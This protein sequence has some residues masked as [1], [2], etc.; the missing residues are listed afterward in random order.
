MRVSKTAGLFAALTISIG[1]LPGLALADDS[2][3]TLPEEHPFPESITSTEDGTLYVS[4]L[5]D[6]GVLRVTPGGEPEIWIEPGAF[7]T[8]S[9]LGVLVDEDRGTLWVCSNDISALGVKGPS[10][11]EGGFLKGFDL[12]T[13]KGKVSY[14]MPSEKSVCN[15]IAIAEDGSTYI[16]NVAGD[17][18]LKL[19]PD[20]DELEVWFTDPDVKGGLDGLAFGPDGNLYANTYTGG[21]LFRFDVEDG[22]AKGFEKLE[23]GPL[24]KPDGIRP[25]E[26]GLVMVQGG[27]AL[28]RITIDDGKVELETIET[29]AEPTGV[30]VVGDTVWVAEGQLAYLFDKK[31]KEEPRPD[32]NLR[33][34]PLQ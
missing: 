17:E 15:D 1:A 6:G 5:S 4:S 13:G 3:I 32:F 34:V 30:T 7:E 20:A 22:E 21:E 29:F 18:I 26:G 2:K 28:N 8:R 19:A 10:D 14:R 25:I 23:T 33:S 12:K 24:T 16:T 31:K 27:G 9:T 11:V